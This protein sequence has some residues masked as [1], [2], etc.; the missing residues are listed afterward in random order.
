MKIS[1][2][3]RLLAI[4][5]T[6]GIVA[7]GC[8]STQE[9]HSLATPYTPVP[10]KELS[11][12]K[13]EMAK[14]ESIQLLTDVLESVEKKKDVYAGPIEINTIDDVPSNPDNISFVMVDGQ[15]EYKCGPGDVLKITEWRSGGQMID[16]LVTIRPDGR[17]SYFF[18]ENLMVDGLSPTQIDRLLS[19]ELEMYVKNPTIDVGIEKYRSRTVSVY[20]E[21]KVI[22]TRSDT[23]P[24]FYPLTG[25]TKALDIILKHGS[26]TDKADLRKVEL[27]RGGKTYALDILKV[28][29]GGD[30]SHNVLLEDHD[31]LVVPL[32]PQFGGVQ[33]TENRIYIFGEVNSPGVYTLGDKATIVDAISKSGGIK[34]TGTSNIN[35]IRGEPESPSVIPVKF[36]KLFC[37]KP[38]LTQ[39]VLLQDLDIVYVGKSPLGTI[40]TALEY[41]IRPILGA[42]V[43]GNQ[44]FPAAFR[45]QYTTGGGLRLDTDVSE[46][47]K[48]EQDV[49]NGVTIIGR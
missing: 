40:T 12:Q 19:K 28:L 16:R 47:L 26:I 23:G 5:I 3:V 24:G 25:P 6:M 34:P 39:K 18:I 30:E 33:A 9:P 1:D 13:T 7:N 14:E 27:S 22:S 21:I 37:K 46:R 45:E 15:P 43:G 31:M 48:R 35:I 49:T 10:V 4:M 29:K 17:I 8:V 32:L 2:K 36:D 38:D 20:G 44:G 42:L 41:Y 11:D